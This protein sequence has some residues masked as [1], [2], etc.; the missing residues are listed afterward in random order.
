[1]AEGATLFRPCMRLF[2][3]S[4]NFDDHRCFLVRPVG[5]FPVP[6]LG[7]G[8]Q[9][10]ERRSRLGRRPTAVRRRASGLERGEHAAKGWRGR[11]AMRGLPQRSE[12]SSPGRCGA[13]AATLYSVGRSGGFPGDLHHDAVMRIG[14]EAPS[15]GPILQERHEGRGRKRDTA[16]SDRRRHPLAGADGAGAGVVLLLG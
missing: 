11:T 15:G 3:S 1:M 10:A 7:S 6:T 16:T 13:G 12:G 2:E 9:R 8:R 14:G 5:G 4:A